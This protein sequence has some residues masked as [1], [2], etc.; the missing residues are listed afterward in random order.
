MRLAE[1]AQREVL[2]F[3]FTRNEDLYDKRVAR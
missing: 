1:R 2:K 3:F